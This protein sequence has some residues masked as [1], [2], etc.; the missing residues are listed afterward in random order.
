MF[1][2]FSPLVKISMN[3]GD[4]D[5][6]GGSV[7]N[8]RPDNADV[9]G[10]LGLI[11]GPGRS[12]GGASDN[13]LQYSWLENPMD[14]VWRVHYIGSQEFDMTEMEH[15]CMHMFVK[16]APW[17]E[18]RTILSSSKPASNS[19]TLLPPLLMKSNNLFFISLISSCHICYICRII[20]FII[21]EKW[22][23]TFSIMLWRFI[24]VV[25]C[26]I[27]LFICINE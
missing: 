8:N 24:Q 27:D 10:D 23:L 11:P 18:Y 4:V 20:Q 13:P 25:L 3:N 21:L 26:I 16:L 9:T 22:L 1:V 5:F 17:S 6:L 14:R 2:C 7:L 19:P 15:P 12:S